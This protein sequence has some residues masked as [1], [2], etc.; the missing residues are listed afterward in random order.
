MI[1]MMGDITYM[2]VKT[3]YIRPSSLIKQTG[4]SKTILKQTDKSR[5]LIK[6]KLIKLAS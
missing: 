6:T 1:N 4:K 3:L 5:S 2:I